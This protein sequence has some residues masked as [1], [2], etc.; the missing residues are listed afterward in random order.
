MARPLWRACVW[1]KTSSTG[2]AVPVIIPIIITVHIVNVKKTSPAFHGVLFAIPIAAIIVSYAMEDDIWRSSRTRYP[3][4]MSVT[5]PIQVVISKRS[6]LE[7]MVAVDAVFTEF[8]QELTE[9]KRRSTGLAIYVTRCKTV[10]E[11]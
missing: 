11:A 2:A 9:R 6:R 8:L 4:A 5:R 3:Q 7:S 10:E 1:A